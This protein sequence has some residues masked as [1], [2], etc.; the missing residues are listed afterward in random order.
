[1]GV[2]LAFLLFFSIGSLQLS[3]TSPAPA[4]EQ[5][6][7]ILS[8]GRAANI[9]IT[10]TSVEVFVPSTGKS[11][12]LP[13][14]PDD[15]SYHTMDGTLICGGYGT[16]TCLSFSSGQW[17]TSNT[18]VETRYSHSSWQTDQGV[19][20]MG[21]AKSGYTSEIVPMDGE[22]GETSFAMQDRIEWA[23]AL[24]D[25]TSE[26]FILTG[27]QHSGRVVA[28]YDM[29]GHVEDLPQ[30]AV[31]RYGHGC[32]SYLRGDG[33][34]VFLVA[35]GYNNK[36][37]TPSM[38]SSTEVLTTGSSAWSMATPLPI[39]MWSVKGVTVSNILY[40]TAGYDGS[41]R[42]AILAWL[43]DEQKWVESG[44]M[45]MARDQHAV[46]T[47]QLDDPVMEFCV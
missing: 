43:D 38:E 14:L 27:G 40:M 11:C 36:Y 8:G 17:I 30:L 24:Q 39:A 25:L 22:Q 44:K 2:R 1:M 45:K 41:Q 23:C 5:K 7:I 19:V 32:G 34:Q 21:G 16:T 3:T 9:P 26:S 37:P 4:T 12:S 31:A 35:G 28:R 15:R 6:G 42:D 20:L 18:L 13:S 47:I 29:Q 46:S 33:T 10:K